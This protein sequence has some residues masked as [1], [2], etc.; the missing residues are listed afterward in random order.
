MHIQVLILCVNGKDRSPK[1]AAMIISA[2][3][4]E[5]EDSLRYLKACRRLCDFRETHGE[6]SWG[7]SHL[8]TKQAVVHFHPRIRNMVRAG[9][10]AAKPI[11]KLWV[12]EREMA[13]FF[14]SHLLEYVPRRIQA[15]SMFSIFFKFSTRSNSS[16]TCLL[17]ISSLLIIRE[18]QA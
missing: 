10:C 6:G 12:T 18:L 3:M 15:C 4:P 13:K 5:C 2:F 17:Q 14:R 1:V 16:S 9:W 7:H 8:S 11:Q